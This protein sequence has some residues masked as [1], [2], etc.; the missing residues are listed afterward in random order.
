[1]GARAA[2]QDTFVAIWRGARRYSPQ[3]DDAA[4]WIWT[5]AVRRLAS[6]EDS[7]LLGWLFLLPLPVACLSLANGNPAGRWSHR[8]MAFFVGFFLGGP[9]AR[10]KSSLLP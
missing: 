10:M 3:G 6:A 4:T 9:Y 5:I 8:V 7:V 2:I 1:M